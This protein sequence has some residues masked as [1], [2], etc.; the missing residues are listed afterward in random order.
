MHEPKSMK[1]AMR[2]LILMNS[3]FGMSVIFDNR[4]KSVHLIEYLHTIIFLV[5]YN[6][7]IILS[8]PIF[9]EYYIISLYKLCDDTYRYS[10]LINILI[11]NGLIIATRAQTKNLRTAIALVESCDRKIEEIGL[12]RSYK[13]M[14]KYQIRG[15]LLGATTILVFCMTVYIWRFKKSTPFSV[16]LY[17]NFIG[18]LPVVITWLCN[19]SFCFWI[20]Y[21]RMK[22]QQLNEVLRSMVM[23][24]PDSPQHQRVL[25]MKYDFQNNGFRSS[26]SNRV[27]ENKEN[28]TV[29]RSVK[30]MHLEMIKIVRIVNNIYGVQILLLMISSV[31]SIT[32]LFYLLY[33]ITWMEL[34]VDSYL[35][36]VIPLTCWIFFYIMLILYINH[37]CAKT[38][39]EAASIGDTICELYEPSTSTEFRAEIQ[40]FTLQL[41]QNPLLFTACGF[42]NLDHAFI[43]GIV[44][45]IT[46]YLI[47]I[48]QVGDMTTS[49]MEVTAAEKFENQSSTIGIDTVTNFSLL[50]EE[51]PVKNSD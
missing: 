19:F 17:L 5:V 1:E 51:G 33:R 22:F 38:I 3:L 47:I 12:P 11:I 50:S 6:V 39:I 40:D 31:I 18:H 49:R 34:T 27:Y 42:F 30:K 32:I 25:K 15:I 8:E 10:S 36:E 41:I 4:K 23:A 46:T 7:V 13:T 37:V 26:K 2:P 21:F 43:Q 20:R 9:S 28:T 48:I 35:Q 44:G 14:M 29:M 24:T 16:K 45:T